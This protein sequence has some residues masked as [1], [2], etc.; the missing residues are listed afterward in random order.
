M[1]K[2]ISQSSIHWEAANAAAVAAVRKARE[3][4]LRVSVVILDRGGHLVAALRDSPSFHT[5]GVA[6][7]KAYTAVSFGMPTANWAE[8]MTN[9]S[10]MVQQGL[11]LRPRT[12]MFGGGLPIEIDGELVGAI[13]VSGA[14]EEQDAEIAAAGIAA[15]A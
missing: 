8:F 1:E 11:P 14:S 4:E 15:I 2:K 9:L 6:E 5:S 3:M 12:A 13:G 10:P 7:D